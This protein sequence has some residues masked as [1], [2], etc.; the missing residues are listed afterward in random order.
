MKSILVTGGAGFIGS[1]VVVELVAAGYRPVII[2]NFSNSEKSVIANLEKLLSQTVSHYD[3]DY[4]DAN[5]VDIIKAENISGIIHFAAYKQ[6][7]ESVNQ[8][9]KYYDNNVAG[10]VKLL[11]MLEASPVKKHRFLV[12]VHGVWRTRQFTGHRAQPGQASDV[13]IRHQQTNG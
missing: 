9:L 12:I 6:V 10:F 5:T 8:P 7:G 11:Q 1:H 2:D 4:R 3:Q 13:A